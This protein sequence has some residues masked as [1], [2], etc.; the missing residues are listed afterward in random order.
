MKSKRRRMF[1]FC[2]LPRESSPR[3]PRARPPDRERGARG[4]H[5]QQPRGQ[6]ER[7]C[8]P[9]VQDEQRPASAAS[10]ALSENPGAPTSA[11]ALNTTFP[12]M[13]ATNTRPSRKMLTAS[14]TPVT[15]VS[16]SSSDGRGPWGFPPVPVP[17]VWLV[18][19]LASACPP[20]P[21]H[22]RPPG[23]KP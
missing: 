2:S 4:H 16:T 12:V 17:A 5:G 7:G 22:R 9:R 19:A 1:A 10:E 20:Q 8:G 11:N 23:A 15:T 18:T 6:A 3:S 14:T 13:L 21:P